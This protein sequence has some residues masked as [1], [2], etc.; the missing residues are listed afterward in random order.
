MVLRASGGTAGSIPVRFRLLSLTYADVPA[1][2]PACCLTSPKS[3]A[4]SSSR[5]T[6]ARVGAGREVGVAHR[7]LDRAVPHQLLDRPQRHAAHREV[8]GEGVPQGVPADLA[9]PGAATRPVQRRSATRRSCGPCREVEEDARSAQVAVRLERRERARRRSRVRL[10]PFFGVPSW[11]RQ[12]FRLTCILPATRSTSCQ[13]RAA[14]RRAACPVLVA[15]TIAGR[16]SS[17]LAAAREQAFG[18]GEVEEVELLLADA[19]TTRSPAPTR[20][21]CACAR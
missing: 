12:R 3:G 20:S 15:S 5:A 1:L 19:G 9:Q 7:H 11:L 21:A 2:L 4:G 10:R 14:A 16:H 8:R 17:T 6:A 13:R 18:L